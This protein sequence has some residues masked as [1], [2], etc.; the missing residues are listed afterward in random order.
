MRLNIFTYQLYIHKFYGNDKIKL[1]LQSVRP[2]GSAT[3]RHRPRRRSGEP[4]R[5]R[6][7]ARRP[8]PCRSRGC[9][10][11]WPP[12]QG[13]GLPGRIGRVGR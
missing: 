2:Q 6:R 5:G 7:S 13:P 1:Y 12:P 9:S 10:T 3:R 4:L 11:A 8:P